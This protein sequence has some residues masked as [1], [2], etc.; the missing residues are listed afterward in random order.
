MNKVVLFLLIFLI[1]LKVW[2]I[3][4]RYFISDEY[5]HLSVI[6]FILENKRLPAYE[7][8]IPYYGHPYMPFFHLLTI[9]MMFFFPLGIIRYI[10][11]IGIPLITTYFLYKLFYK[12]DK[13]GIAAVLANFVP[14]Y[15]IWSS[16][17]FYTEGLFVLLAIGTL[18]YYFNNKNRWIILY[19]LTLLTKNY[20]SLGLIFPMLYDSYKKK[21][22]KKFKIAFLIS[23]FGFLLQYLM[24]YPHGKP[25][26]IPAT[27]IVI[28]DLCCPPYIWYYDPVSIYTFLLMSGVIA[29]IIFIPFIWKEYKLEILIFLPYMIFP[30]IGILDVRRTILISPFIFLFIYLGFK[31]NNKTIRNL[32]ILFILSIFLLNIY[33]A[34]FN[35]LM[36]EGFEE[37]AGF[38]RTLPNDTVIFSPITFE[39]YWHTKKP[40]IAFERNL[41]ENNATHFYWIK[42]WDWWYQFVS[43]NVSTLEGNGWVSVFENSNI[44]ILERSQAS[45]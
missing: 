8:L 4:T 29:F 23:I 12:Y 43:P 26:A 45:P 9:F 18:Y 5:Y 10:Y 15:F 24:I 42:N 6:N 38:I 30:I 16:V 25:Y 39:L 34:N 32:Y 35:F 40:V 1:V 17:S 13:T 27:N 19:I 2:W 31:N 37:A 7:Y 11:G 44:K 41:T 28:L 3:S 21:E 20:I 36:M 22:W 14:A 33:R